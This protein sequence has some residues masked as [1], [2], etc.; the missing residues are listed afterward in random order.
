MHLRS[1]PLAALLV[2]ALAGTAIADVDR[3]RTVERA[4]TS[5][6][7]DS[8][9]VM[10]LEVTGVIT[11]GNPP[12]TRTHAFQINNG[13]PDDHLFQQCQRLA[14]VAMTKPGRFA[15]EVTYMSRANTRVTHCGL[16]LLD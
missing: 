10:A 5:K 7:V 8:N 6:H 14:I 4:T 12:V 13:A 9:Q 3:F 2:A 15:L 1:L 16:A 11:E